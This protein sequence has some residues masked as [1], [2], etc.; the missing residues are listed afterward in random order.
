MGASFEGYALK[1]VVAR[2]A[3]KP[4]E[5]FFWATHGG[6]ELDLLVVRGKQRL[7]F[8]FKRTAAPQ[9]T[10]SMHVALQDLKLDRIDVI[11]LGPHTFPLAD[12]I[13][14][15]PVQELSSRLR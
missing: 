2:L 10:K 13:R 9:V 14:A 4:E 3:A 1:T 12:R 7:G 5:C 15:V 8:E 6:A 11:H